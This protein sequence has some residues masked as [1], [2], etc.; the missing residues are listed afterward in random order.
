MAAAVP[1]PL[2]AALA[3]VSLS[4]TCLDASRLNQ[5][6]EWIRDSTFAVDMSR[7]A[8]R[9]H[10][11]IDAQIAEA[12]GIRYG[13]AFRETRGIPESIRLREECTARLFHVITRNHG[14]DSVA[15]RRAAERRNLA[16]DGL[17]MW[18]PAFVMLALVGRPIARRIARA[19]DVEDRVP[20]LLSLVAMTPIV[21]AF[22]VGLT[23]MWSWLVETARFRDSH[24]SYRVGRLFTSRHG[25]YFFA[26]AAGVFLVIAWMEYRRSLRH[27]PMSSRGVYRWRRRA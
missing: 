3:L 26:G 22:F 1:A 4:G 2:I 9:D 8:H 21:A 14:V 24:M 17:T 11:T 19:F 7:A 18:L 10:L 23:Q 16:F 12:N 15:I 25:W 6:C 13:D 20:R 27:P 5:A